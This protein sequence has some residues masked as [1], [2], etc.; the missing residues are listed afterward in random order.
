MYAFAAKKYFYL[1]KTSGLISSLTASC[2]I[3]HSQR[4]FT[5]KTRLDCF[6]LMPKF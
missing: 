4:F 2:L 6:S 5:K 1:V 3:K